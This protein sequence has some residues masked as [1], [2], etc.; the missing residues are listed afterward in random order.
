MKIGFTGTRKGITNIQKKALKELACKIDVDEFHH[1]DCVGADEEAHK[2]FGSITKII[3]HPP[4]VK[5][6][7]QIASRAYCKADEYR[8]AKSY[9]KRN[10][11]IVDD[12][13]LLIAIPKENKEPSHQRAGGTWATIRYARKV[14]KKIT[15]IWPD[16][17]IWYENN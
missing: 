6:K 2:I 16:G 4:I 14:S 9:L 3:L 17:S 12:C 11:N 5:T 7:N 15:I 1:G 8:I 13:N 10:H